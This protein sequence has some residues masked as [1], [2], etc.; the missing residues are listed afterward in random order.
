[1]KLAE[2][3]SIV[4]EIRDEINLTKGSD[5]V[6]HRKPTDTKTIT[7]DEAFNR[8]QALLLKLAHYKEAITIA[9]A[10]TT[11]TLP[12]GDETNL[13]GLRI[14]IDILRE[15]VA[16]YK[17]MYEGLRRNLN[18]TEYEYVGAERVAVE[19]LVNLPEGEGI[20]ELKTAWDFGKSSLKTLESILARKNWDVVVPEYT[21]V[22]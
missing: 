12:N 3:I 8:Y 17:V 13:N 10:D 4:G 19:M 20:E 6:L 11:V 16:Q 7:L 18:R 2:A 22:N 5:F 14:R 1:M 15:L 9:N 21:V